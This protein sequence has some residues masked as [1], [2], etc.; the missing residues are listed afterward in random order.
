MADE[1]YSNNVTLQLETCYT[2]SRDTIMDRTVCTLNTRW[3]VFLSEIG[4]RS[5]LKITFD[6]D[7]NRA[8]IFL[9][10]EQR[11][12]RQRKKNKWRNERQR[13]SW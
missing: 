12:E 5:K 4:E 7:I 9:R 11:V 6:R 2:K 3:Y 1:K 10:T 13:R 8:G